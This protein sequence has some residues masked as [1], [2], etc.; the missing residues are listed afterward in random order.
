VFPSL[1]S[2]I[3]VTLLGTALGGFSAWSAIERAKDF[4]AIRVGPWHAI[5]YSGIAEVDPY[6]I[7]RTVVD[8]SVPLG[9][10]EGITFDASTD[11][12][13]RQLVLECDYVVEGVTPSAKL[14]T[15]AAL[16]ARGRSIEAAPGSRSGAYSGAILR[17][18]DGSFRIDVSRHPRPGN[19]IGVSGDG[20]FRLAL[21]LYDTPLIST[22]GVSELDMPAIRREGCD[23]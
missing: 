22:S 1:P 2:L 5:S 9:A 20:D 12:D 7:A 4:G 17:F 23:R 3:A 18:P 10:T 8:G 16:D 6:T 15:L 14:W 13:G 11:R 19:W 21:R